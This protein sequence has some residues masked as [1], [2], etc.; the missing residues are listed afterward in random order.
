VAAK[1]VTNAGLDATDLCLT[2]PI[3]MQAVTSFTNEDFT[4]DGDASGDELSAGDILY[5]EIA[6]ETDD[7]GGSSNGH[8]EIGLIQALVPCR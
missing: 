6:F 2:E 7:T 8:G 3:N 1:R 4:I 5:I